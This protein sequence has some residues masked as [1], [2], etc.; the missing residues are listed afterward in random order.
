MTAA[1][2]PERGPS[3]RGMLAVFSAAK[4]ALHLAAITRYGWFRDEFYYVVCARH[5]AWGYVDQPPLSIAVLAMVTRIF[6]ESLVAIRLVPA[7]VGA[8]TV[9][10]TGAIARELGGGRFAQA[11]ACLGVIVAPSFLSIGHY[12]SMNAFDL[13]LWTAAIRVLI[14]CLRGGAVRDW[15]VLGVL[16]GL[17]LLNKISVLWLGL[18][19]GVGL[20]LTPHRRVLLTPG[21]WLAAAIAAAMFVPHVLWQVANGWPTL[22]FMRNATGRKMA[23]ITPIQFL[24]RQLQGMGPGNALV[25]IAGLGYALLARGGA[26]RLFAWIY[27][28]VL[29]LLV[30]GGRSRAGYLSVAYP[31]LFALGGLAWE[32]LAAARGRWLKP[33]AVAASL[34]TL[35]WLPLALPVLPVD[36]FIRYQAALGVKPGTE[37][38]K[39]IGPLGQHYADM[40]GWEAMVDGV[41]RAAARLSDE[42]RRKAV[43]FGQNYGEAGAVDV[44]GRAR[45]LPRAVSSHNNYW[46]WGPGDWDGGVM[47]VIGGGR[48]DNA[49]WFESIAVVDSVDHPLAM[50]YE[51]HLDISI[52]RRFKMPPAQ[53][54]PQLKHYD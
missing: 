16:L 24:A 39:R 50:P 46:L 14:A 44:L 31:M 9:W 8:G 53:A 35:V 20:V 21:P 19:I 18:G 26:L 52:A 3:H 54:W 28:A 48:D 12:Y 45:G 29:A 2:L 7:L 47:I 49:A 6:G 43:V 40:H 17:G 25:W 30:A 51:R 27:L 5:L 34:A 36:D 10:L 15:A 33:V 22:E 11:L 1:P 41:A 38:R 13:L 37:E 32:R 4:V 23:P 42:E